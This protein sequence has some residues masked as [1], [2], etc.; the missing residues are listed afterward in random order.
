MQIDTGVK[1]DTEWFAAMQAIK[2]QSGP[3]P[4]YN[5]L[6]LVDSSEPTFCHRLVDS[7]K[8]TY[9]SLKLCVGKGDS[10]PLLPTLLKQ[11]KATK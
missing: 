1:P 10:A 7:S 5:S 8:P 2:D 3:E 11:R 6:R 9:H 4:T